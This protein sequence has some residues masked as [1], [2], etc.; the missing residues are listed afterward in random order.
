M[1]VC[2]TDT[3]DNSRHTVDIEMIGIR[4]AAGLFKLDGKAQCLGSLSRQLNG[5][6]I[7]RQ[8][9][10]AIVR[11]YFYV[12]LTPERPRPLL[13]MLR[14]PAGNP[15]EFLLIAAAGFIEY[16]TGLS[17]DIC[18]AAAD[19]PPDIAGGLIINAPLWCGGDEFP[20]RLYRIDAVFRFNAGMSGLPCRRMQI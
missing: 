1:A 9:V 19:N 13:K 4:T 17:D 8:R 12:C 16:L 5:R 14:D 2:H 10:R 6:C 7:D 18:C 20:C 11:T 3:K 15:I